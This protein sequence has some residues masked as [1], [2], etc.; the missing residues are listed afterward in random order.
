MAIRAIRLLCE[1]ER[2]MSSFDDWVMTRSLSPEDNL[3]VIDQ[4][5]LYLSML[6]KL[7][8]NHMISFIARQLAIGHSHPLPFSRYGIS[9]SHDGENG[10]PLSLWERFGEAA[11][12]PEAG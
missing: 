4:S 10:I 1:D 12:R 11:Y 5:M 3:F 9:G 8:S 7:K 2:V 6:N